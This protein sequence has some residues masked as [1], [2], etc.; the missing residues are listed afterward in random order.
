M[1]EEGN[2]SYNVVTGMYRMPFENNILISILSVMIL[3]LFY[4]V[5]RT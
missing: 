2:V 4:T 1:K 5:G 3:R